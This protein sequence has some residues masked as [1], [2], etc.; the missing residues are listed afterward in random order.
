MF[1]LDYIIA[2][3]SIISDLFSYKWNKNYLFHINLEYIFQF[4]V[5]WEQYA[6]FEGK[7]KLY[8]TEEYW[9]GECTLIKDRIREFFLNNFP[10]KLL[11]LIIG[12]PAVYYTDPPTFMMVIPNIIQYIYYYII[13][14]ILDHFKIS[15]ILFNVIELLIYEIIANFIVFYIKILYNYYWFIYVLSELNLFFIYM[16]KIIYIIN[17]IFLTEISMIK[18]IIINIY[19]II[20]LFINL[21][22]I[23]YKNIGVNLLDDINYIILYNQ[24][25]I[26]DFFFILIFQYVLF[27]I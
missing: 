18:Y 19:L 6:V 26:G 13:T 1:L 11:S 8:N 5:Y 22:F 27:M 9:W 15:L 12:I 24:L 21:F 2:F 10:L 17:N 7:Y 3:F 4:S 20:K 14:A 16:W 25:I 23:L